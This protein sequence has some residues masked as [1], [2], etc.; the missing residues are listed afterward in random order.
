MRKRTL[1]S[2][3]LADLR[4]QLILVWRILALHRGIDLQRTRRIISQVGDSFYIKLRRKGWKE[5]KW[6]QFIKIDSNPNISPWHVLMEYV[7]RTA[8]NVKSGDFLLW[9]LDGKKVLCANTINSLTKSF[10]ASMGIPTSHWTAHST[11]G[12]GVLF[13]KN[14]GFSAEQVCELGA[15]KNAQAFTSHYLRLGA[16]ANV[17]KI[18]SNPQVH[19]TSPSPTGRRLPGGT[20]REEVT[21][22]AKHKGKASPTPPPER[23]NT[24]QGKDANSHPHGHP[25]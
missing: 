5:E 19:K 24:Q 17:E 6:E 21:G 23:G 4:I 18:F 15:W 20:T 8:K 10:L 12:A 16:A 11:R 1:S 3:P 25:G 14:R 7:K 13:Y 2:L 22:R 9:S